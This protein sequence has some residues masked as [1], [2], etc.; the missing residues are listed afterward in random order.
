MI[1][2]RNNIYR[3]QIPE[4]ENPKKVVNIVE[5]NLNVNK[6]QR[7]NGLPLDLARVAKAFDRTQLKI[8]TAKWILQKFAI[9]I[10]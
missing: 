3:K 4:N 10:A 2:L 8:L 9:T 7:G 6:Q 1:D 5:E